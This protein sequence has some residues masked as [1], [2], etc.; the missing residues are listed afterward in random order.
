MPDRYGA[1]SKDLPILI[2]GR[3]F[4]STAIVS[5]ATLGP[6]SPPERLSG[7]CAA[8][9]WN[10]AGPAPLSVVATVLIPVVAIVLIAVVAIVLIAVVAIVLIAVVAI[11]LIAVV[12]IVLIAVVAIVLIAVAAAVLGRVRHAVLGYCSGRRT[13][14]RLRA[15]ASATMTA[16]N[17][18][19][20]VITIR[21]LPPLVSR[22]HASWPS[23]HATDRPGEREWTWVASPGPP[24]VRPPGHGRSSM[25][26]W[27]AAR[28]G[29]GDRRGLSPP[30]E[31]AHHRE[32]PAV[33]IGVDGQTQRVVDPRRVL[34]DGL[35]GEEQL[36]G[37]PR[38][39]APF[40][41]QREDLLLPR[42]SART[43]WFE[44]VARAT[45]TATT[46][47]SSAVPPAATSRRSARKVSTFA[48]RCLRR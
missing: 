21:F 40:R 18:R 6:V 17:R 24:R 3:P 39:A 13:D 31:V 5:N 43:A 4:P 44:S 48:I 12:A 28:R 46:S 34:D 10:R 8:A 38:V 9:S 14:H 15:S 7:S 20:L 35:L 2:P 33:R 1:G 27:G 16:A 42:V 45:I 36:R 37:N 30:A 41:H 23:R 26:T 47:G 25:A 22:A 29:P 11:V 32:Y 19:A